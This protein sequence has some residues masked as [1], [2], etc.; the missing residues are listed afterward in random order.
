VYQ[1]SKAFNN[2]ITGYAPDKEFCQVTIDQ[3]KRT[4]FIIM[5]NHAKGSLPQNQT[6]KGVK[7]IHVL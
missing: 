6:H 4:S 7:T 2:E 3:L 1:K 5:I